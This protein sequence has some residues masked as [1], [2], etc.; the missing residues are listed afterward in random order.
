M[1]ADRGV[2]IPR[3]RVDDA[4]SVMSTR[5]IGQ[6]ECRAFEF[7][8]RFLVVLAREQKISLGEW[9]SA[10]FGIQGQCV[11]VRA[12][13]ILVVAAAI[14]QRVEIAVR[15]HVQRIA[16]DRAPV[17]FDGGIELSDGLKCVGAVV[18]DVRHFRHGRLRLVE[19]REGFAVPVLVRHRHAQ[20]MLQRR[21]LA[22]ILR[23]RQRL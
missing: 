14:Q 5:I 13:K 7:H 20:I 15:V 23:C 6:D 10:G 11:V 2:K 3:A 17:E 21:R 1:L 22:R 12:Q 16:R 8:P 19:Q 4:Q 18:I 9:Q